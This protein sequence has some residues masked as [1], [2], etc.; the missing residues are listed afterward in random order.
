MID[1]LRTI[2]KFAKVLVSELL[3]IILLLSLCG[4]SQLQGLR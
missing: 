3:A 4:N 1:V 2:F